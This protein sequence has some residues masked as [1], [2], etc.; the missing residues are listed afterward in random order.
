MRLRL[1][2]SSVVHDE[3]GGMMK[4][5]CVQVEAPRQRAVIDGPPTLTGD[6]FLSTPTSA[7]SAAC[8]DCMWT[9]LAQTR[10]TVASRASRALHFREM[11]PGAQQS[12]DCFGRQSWLYVPYCI[13][14][15]G[16]S[17]KHGR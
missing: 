1:T 13:V 5:W 8:T 9:M 16:P 11:V 2:A 6:F 10:M 12:P 15:V 14:R 17:C 7:L 3:C 4:L